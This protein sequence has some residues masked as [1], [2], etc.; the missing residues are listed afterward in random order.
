[1]SEDRVEWGHYSNILFSRR[2]AFATSGQASQ[3]SSIER[4]VA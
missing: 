1:M 4:G 2:L 3:L